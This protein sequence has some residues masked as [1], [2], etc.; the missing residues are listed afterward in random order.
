LYHFFDDLLK[1]TDLMARAGKNQ[2]SDFGK[3]CGLA[4]AE[5]NKDP[6]H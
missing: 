5:R 4:A 1:T 6:L 3:A 2:K